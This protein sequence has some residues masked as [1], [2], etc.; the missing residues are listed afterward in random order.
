MCLQDLQVGGVV[1]DVRG[2]D[3]QEFADEGAEFRPEGPGAHR[4]VGKFKAQP[5]D[6][7]VPDDAL[8]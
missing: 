2:D 7:G 3:V 8:F 6:V 1:G 5:V 4:E